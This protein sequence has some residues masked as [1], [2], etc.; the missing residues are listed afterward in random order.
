MRRGSSV[1]CTTSDTHSKNFHRYLTQKEIA[2]RF[3]PSKT[4][5][6]RTLQYLRTNQF[7]L[8]E[9]S[10]NR[11]TITVRGT[12]KQ[13]QRTFD[14]EIADYAIGKQR[15]YANDRDPALPDQIAASIQAIEG[16]SSLARPQAT[17][18]PYPPCKGSEC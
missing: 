16:L 12:R 15:F 5:Y 4:S 6:D 2:D 1:I 9:G 17:D 10:L 13:A 8:L 18:Q 7:R 11:L 14:V 3:G